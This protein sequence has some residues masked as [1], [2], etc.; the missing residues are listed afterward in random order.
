M[1]GL[2]FAHAMTSIAQQSARCNEHYICAYF[3]ALPLLDHSID[4]ITANL[5]V[6]W[7]LNFTS[8]LKEWCRVLKPK[9]NLIFPTFGSNTLHELRL[10]WPK[11]DNEKHV[12]LFFHK[13]MK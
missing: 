10:F 13:E 1:V 5:T 2:D 7:A 8:V 11:I 4:L 3:D 12:N 6:Q 9:A